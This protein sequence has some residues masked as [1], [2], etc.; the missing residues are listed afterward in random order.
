ML[1]RVVDIVMALLGLLILSPLFI[2]LPILS[3]LDSP[4]SIF[5]CA[6]RVGK[7]RQPC[8]RQNFR[9]M[10]ANADKSGP[11]VSAARGPLV[12]GVAWKPSGRDASAD[13]YGPRGDEHFKAQAGSTLLC[14]K[15]F[16]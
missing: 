8:H 2:M 6:W 3:R 12:A 16:A 4:G 14:G 11:P 7:D 15:V 9:T 1:K 13:Q 10:V 5:H